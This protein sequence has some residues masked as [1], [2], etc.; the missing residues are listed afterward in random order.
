VLRLRE[1]GVRGRDLGHPAEHARAGGRGAAGVPVDVDEHV[2][3]S[4]HQDALAGAAELVEDV[5]ALV[6]EAEYLGRHLEVIA[7]ERLG[8]VRQLGL[9]GVVAAARGHVGG[10]DSD[11]AKQ[12]VRGFAEHLEVAALGGVAVVIDPLGKHSCPVE[13]QRCVEVVAVRRRRGVE[14]VEERALVIVEHSARPDAVRAQR[15]HHRDEAV[16]AH[17]LQLTDRA[18]ARLRVRLS[19][20]LVDQSIRQI[21]H[22]GQ[23]RPRQAQRRP[24][25]RHE[26][27]HAVLAAGDPVRQE[28]AEERPAQAGAVADR[29]IYL[30]DGR[31][32]VV[33]EPERFAPQRLEQAVSHEALD[34]GAQR[35]RPHAHR[36][37]DRR[38][39]L[40]RGPG[41]AVA[42]AHLD[43]RQEVDGIERVT[44][45]EALGV[46]H[47]G[48]EP[49]RKQAGGRR[50][51]HDVRP[52][53][54]ARG[55][56]Q[57]PLQV[58]AL[59][60]A[61]LNE[62]DAVN[63]LLDARRERDL[64]LARERR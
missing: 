13:A 28:R 8:E 19:H 25:L 32:V 46:L 11:V 57:R 58:L 49:R 16:V 50:G 14:G 47:V 59:R 35:E 52:G 62:V 44:D 63:R 41:R 54:A 29:V 48:L 1:E 36:A 31:D 43:E 3:R 34:L 7:G 30:L 12:R 24:E 17:L 20:E 55:R 64:S 22:V 42:S 10:V 27:A 60:G 53:R 26:V 38:G 4:G 6:V 9:H 39:A 21:R 61:L 2:L 37:V 51:E 5:Q 23:L 40:H 56:E 15:L 18:V 33:D 45:R